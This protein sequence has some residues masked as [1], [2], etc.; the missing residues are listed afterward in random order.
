V[1]A[2]PNETNDPGK[3][4][5]LRIIQRSHEARAEEYRR[6]AAEHGVQA[7]K[8]SRQI[9]ELPCD[10]ARTR[11]ELIVHLGWRHKKTAPLGMGKPGLI[12]IHDKILKGRT[13]V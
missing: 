3:L 7:V 4:K 12:A 13:G 5:L 8:V 9:A 2:A 11:D 1:T 10:I 6:Q